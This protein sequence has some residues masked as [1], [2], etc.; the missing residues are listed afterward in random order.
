LRPAKVAHAA[1]AN[2]ANVA[3]GHV[4]NFSIENGKQPT[5]Y[6]RA[7]GLTRSIAQTSV[8]TFRLGFN[9]ATF[10]KSLILVLS[11]K[12]KNRLLP[13]AEYFGGWWAVR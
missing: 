4:T 8:G 9:L 13:L 10:N 1:A 7:E 11:R 3:F 12:L 6:V 2:S 5:N